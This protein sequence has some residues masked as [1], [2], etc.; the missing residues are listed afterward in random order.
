MD[1]VVREGT[2]RAS[3]S[4]LRGWVRSCRWPGRHP[5]IIRCRRVVSV[6]ITKR[7]RRRS[8]RDRSSLSSRISAAA[9]IAAS[10]FNTSCS[11]DLPRSTCS[12]SRDACSQRTANTVMGRGVELSLAQVSAA[13]CA[14]QTTRRGHGATQRPN[15]LCCKCENNLKESGHTAASDSFRPIDHHRPR[16]LNEQRAIIGRFAP[17][18][19]RGER[20]LCGHGQRGCSMRQ[21]T[22]GAGL[23]TLQQMSQRLLHVLAAW[24]AS[25]AT[26]SRAHASVPVRAAPTMRWS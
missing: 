17:G 25:F 22:Q 4:A 5:A 8:L 3:D 7:K 11:D 10:R 6:W 16:R 23:M 9:R 24:R 26:C 12:D 18:S 20:Q 2:L 21:F 14:L 13:R 19:R 15:I 1:Q